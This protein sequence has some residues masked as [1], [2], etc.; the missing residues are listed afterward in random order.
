MDSVAACYLPIKAVNYDAMNH[1]L[2]LI[3]IREESLGNRG[4][5]AH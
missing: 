2:S 4:W 1:R 3:R 5:Q